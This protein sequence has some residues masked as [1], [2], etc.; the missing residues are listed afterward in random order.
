MSY[1]AYLM[2]LSQ[3]S[4]RKKAQCVIQGSVIFVESKPSNNDWSISTKIFDSEHG[5]LPSTLK[6][7]LTSSGLLRWQERGAY[8]KLD[9]ETNHV[10]LIQEIQAS[11]KYIPF[12]H[13][14]S[15]FTDVATE[16][17]QILDDFSLADNNSYR[18]G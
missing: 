9:A 4:T 10:Y 18:I 8:L 13:I 5:K 14:M 11:K 17:K 6:K 7:S 12:R 2:V 15:D 1:N 3:L 16:W